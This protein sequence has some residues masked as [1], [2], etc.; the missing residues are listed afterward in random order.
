MAGTRLIVHLSL[1]LPCIF[2]VSLII[3]LQS[4]IRSPLPL[5][6]PPPS[7]P[8]LHILLTLS[9][10]AYFDTSVSSVARHISSNLGSSLQCSPIQSRKIPS[11]PPLSS[12]PTLT[13]NSRKGYG[14]NCPDH[15]LWLIP[16]NDNDVDIHLWYDLENVIDFKFVLIKAE[17]ELDRSSPIE[18]KVEGRRV[19][20]EVLGEFLK[21]SEE[22]S[23]FPTVGGGG[24]LVLSP[25]LCQVVGV[26]L[27]S[28]FVKGEG[29][30]GRR[31][32]GKVTFVFGTCGRKNRR[33]DFDLDGMLKSTGLG[34]FI[35]GLDGL[36]A[37]ISV[38]SRDFGSCDLGVPLESNADIKV[39]DINSMPVYSTSFEVAGDRGKIYKFVIYV[40]SAEE[41]EAL[42]IKDGRKTISGYMIPEEGSVHISSSNNA[43]QSLDSAA[44]TFANAMLSLFDF[45]A[46]LPPTTIIAD[47]IDYTDRVNIESERGGELEKDGV[48]RRLL[49]E[50]WDYVVSKIAR[51]R[52]IADDNQG[53]SILPNVADKVHA[54]V[55][56][57]NLA[58]SSAARGNVRDAVS[59]LNSAL[60]K[61]E[62]AEADPTMVSL[63]YFPDEHKLA[64][65]LPLWA[66]LA[67]PM[68]VGL[69]REVKRYRQLRAEKIK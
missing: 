2:L 41:S 52:T 34:K 19:R 37:D 26:K 7:R 64:V 14:Y 58:K 15:D 50:R 12:L 5:P 59:H 29:E 10:D 62:H 69:V 33:N 45:P 23:E 11:P 61:I 40:P 60:R 28:L 42:K 16:Y 49:G 13:W 24:G 30:G 35:K 54:S 25:V 32:R 4:P 65:L 68:I 56:L 21:I 57:L 8:T 47:G 22:K 9:D 20:I 39:Q 48:A 18:V 67:L 38:E 51:L 53:M 6:P 31:G 17:E 66:P 36:V 3:H 1:M 46:P 43:S 55:D 63:L 27:A 44:E